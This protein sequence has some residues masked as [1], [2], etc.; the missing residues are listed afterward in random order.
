MGLTSILAAGAGLGLLSSASRGPT[1]YQDST[2]P[3]PPPPSPESTETTEAISAAK[4]R[5]RQQA[6]AAY[7]RSDTILTGPGGLDDTPPTARKTLLGE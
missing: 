2:P 1:T 4:K 3:P 7:G 5:R 6:I